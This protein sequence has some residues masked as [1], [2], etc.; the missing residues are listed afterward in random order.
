MIFDYMIKQN[1]VRTPPA[2]MGRILVSTVSDFAD[3]KYNRCKHRLRTP[4]L[5]KLPALVSVPF[6]S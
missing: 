3:E 4:A 6:S 2:V 1:V 5:A